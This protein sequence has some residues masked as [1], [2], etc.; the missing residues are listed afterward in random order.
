MIKNFMLVVLAFNGMQLAEA[1]ES[2][3]DQSYTLV[4]EGYDWGP[5]TSK[6]ILHLSD[7]TSVAEGANYSIDVLRESDC[8]DANSPRS[9]GTLQVVT[10]YVSDAEGNKMETGKNIT[11]HVG[12]GPHIQIGSPIVYFFTEGCRGNQWT[13]YQL[14]ITNS[15]NKSIWNKESDRIMPLVDEF[16]LSGKFSSNNV[17]LTYASFSPKMGEGKKPL[18]IWLHGGGEGGTD[19]SIVL[20]AN[21]AANYASNEIQKIFGG[22]YVLTPQ[23]PTRWMHGISGETTR[24]N[25]PD[26][27]SETLMDLIKDFVSKHPDIDS[28]RIYVG[29]CSNG[30]YMTQ[31]LLLNNPDY[32]AAAYPSALAFFAEFLSEDDIRSLAKQSIWYMHSKDDPVTKA[33]V[34]V[35]PTFDLLMKAGAKDVHLSLYD[36]VVDLYGV[37]GGNDYH[38]NGHFSWVYSHRNHASKVIDGQEVT[39]MEWMAGKSK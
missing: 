38:L 35:I 34:T 13:N 26:I 10:A 5:A 30:G 39:V 16:D 25:E 29:G 11:L 21:R 18:I 4:V 19:P 31:E 27:Y 23:T 8:L 17:D 32:F 12:V 36:H 1:Q 24:G 15:K 14:T 33:D 3:A 20:L 9:K 7:T 2:N 6:V 22:A 37:Y 28:N